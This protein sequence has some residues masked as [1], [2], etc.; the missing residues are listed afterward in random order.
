MAS[1]KDFILS[2]VRV[3]LLQIF[4]SSPGEIYYVR[5]LVRATDEEINAVRR[6]LLRMESK[7]MVRK[8]K[9]GNRLY[10]GFFKG[11][12]FYNELIH[13]VAKTTGL[14]KIIIKQQKR[15][16]KIKFAVLSGR[17]AR[18]QERNEN[19]IDLLLVGDLVM[20]EV[21]SLMNQAEKELG[22]EINYSVMTKDEFSF[23][24]KR[25]DP[26]LSQILMDSRIILIGDELE[27]LK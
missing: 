25:L 2:K 20:Q 10:Y 27:L 8:E 22:R 19:A 17:F 26:F 24:K 16:G 21:T 11:Y 1:L 5:E 13:L 9:R 23:R 7:G 6:E 14:G 4:L 18:K 15:L 3:K 12:Q